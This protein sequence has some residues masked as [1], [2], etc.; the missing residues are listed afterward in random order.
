MSSNVPQGPQLTRGRSRLIT[1]CRFQ[2]G[3]DA[4]VHDVAAAAIMHDVTYD[5]AK[6]WFMKVTDPSWKRGDHSVFSVVSESQGSAV[7]DDFLDQ[8]CWFLSFNLTRS[9]RWMSIF[10]P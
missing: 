9:A 1:S 3:L 7:I 4:Y 2:I 10:A 5:L 6:Y 8:C